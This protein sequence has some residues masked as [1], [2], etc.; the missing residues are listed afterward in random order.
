[1]KHLLF[2]VALFVLMGCSNP[3]SEV[4]TPIPEH[5]TPKE[6]VSVLHAPEPVILRIPPEEYAN[7]SLYLRGY[8]VEF[9]QASTTPTDSGVVV[10][11][12]NGT[13]VVMGVPR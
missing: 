4:G 11:S 1:M 8:Q 2:T 5:A 13:P 7:I 9:L 3:V 12:I 6:Q 10:Y